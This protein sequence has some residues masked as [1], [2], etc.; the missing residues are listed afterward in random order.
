MS[1]GAQSRKIGR[2]R[3]EDWM[4]GLGEAGLEG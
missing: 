3:P 4:N 2:R 1:M